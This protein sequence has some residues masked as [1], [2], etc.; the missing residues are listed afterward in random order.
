MA[1]ILFAWELGWH[2]S[3]LS[4]MAMLARPLAQ[5]GHDI[6][7]AAR[8]LHA[9]PEFFS[10]VPVQY[11]QAPF[12][13][14]RA[15]QLPNYLSY[16][17][18]LYSSGYANA[19][20][21][22]V[23]V[24]AWLGI[25]KSFAPDVILFDHSPT[26]LLASRALQAK[27]FLIGSGFLVPTTEPLLG[28]FPHTPNDAAVLEQLRN[29]EK[30][31]CGTI[32]QATSVHGLAPL[33]ELSDLYD[34]V[35][36]RFILSFP[37]LDPFGPRSEPDYYGVW[38]RADKPAPQ[39]SGDCGPRVYAYLNEFPACETLLKELQSLDADVI[40]YAPSVTTERKQSLTGE[41]LHF[42]E[43]LLDLDAVA[44]DCDLFISH[45]AHTSTSQLLLGAVPQLMIP[46]YN[47]Q[48][49]TA[50]RVKELGAGLIAERDRISY[51]D[52]LNQLLQESHFKHAAQAFAQRHEGFNAA[53]SQQRL[54]AQL[55]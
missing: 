21:L 5:Q 32:N 4:N 38:S 8:E 51:T 42:T 22:T 15:A 45:G 31:V 44:G 40:V 12:Q 55:V 37:E 52:L 28:L 7:V 20:E 26:A 41:R 11:Y 34:A 6:A 3:H 24:S 47:E 35:D 2:M 53:E 36:G 29:D 18:L 17:H 43:E 23:L 49:F 9:V 13:Q 10:A 30:I 19:R 14:G 25:L 39:W 46:I 33:A 27:R 1:R 48:L 50:H 54:L 16:A